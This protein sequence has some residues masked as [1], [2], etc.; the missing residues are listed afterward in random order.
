MQ[1]FLATG[2]F[3]GNVCRFHPGHICFKRVRFEVFKAVTIKKAVFW[4]VAPCRSGV[5]RRFGERI[6]S[7]FRVE[8]KIRKSACKASV[9]D[10]KSRLLTSLT[11]ALRLSAKVDTNF[12]NKRRSLG[13]YS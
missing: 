11:D 10:V 7:I 6:A 13:R 3:I 2:A 5:N 4:D 8:G 9:R 12:A 1:Q